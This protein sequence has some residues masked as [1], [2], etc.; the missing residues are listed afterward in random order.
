MIE[1]ALTSERL[2]GYRKD[3]TR[4]MLHKD[5]PNDEFVRRVMSTHTEHSTTPEQTQFSQIKN[6]IERVPESKYPP[7]ILE[8]KNVSKVA[9]EF[10]HSQNVANSQQFSQHLQNGEPSQPKVKVILMAYMRG[11][12][13]LLGHYF[14]DHPQGFY[15]FEGLSSLYSTLYGMGPFNFVP[16]ITNK[17]NGAIRFNSLS[18]KKLVE[19]FL[20]DFFSCKFENLSMEMKLGEFTGISGHAW[21]PY[22]NCVHYQTRVYIYSI[23][24]NCWSYIAQFCSYSVDT[25]LKHR[26]PHFIKRAM[27]LSGLHSEWILSLNSNIGYLPLVLGRYS[28]EFVLRQFG[29]Y[30]NCLNQIV[31]KSM[32]N[33]CIPKLT[34]ACNKSTV[35]A[36]KVLRLNMVN[37]ESMLPRH[38]DWKIIY[39]IRDP[40]AVILSQRNQFMYFTQ[41][42]TISNHA[43][44][45]CAK[46][47]SDIE[48]FRRLEKIYP[49]QML[50]LKY[51]DLAV[52]P[53]QNLKSIYK[54]LGKVWQPD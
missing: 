34:E 29:A 41:N 54:T 26:C 48:A 52:E 21:K 53:I 43:R 18:E 39:L 8:F 7:K 51:E 23:R 10:K 9:K 27:E 47:M 50:Q 46:M 31:L 37:L 36:T 12:S 11:G 1:T 3:S 19:K 15:W 24:R 49:A 22:L 20:N 16:Y 42:V 32:V 35:I 25:N 5:E 6:T 4:N 45:Q 17:N 28:R 33:R 14:S 30:V 44:V 2:I 40:R 38:P 13:S